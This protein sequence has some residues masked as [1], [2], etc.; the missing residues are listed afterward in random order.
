MNAIEWLGA[1]HYQICNG[2][3]EQACY[4]GYIDRLIEEW[5]NASLWVEALEKEVDE[6][7]K[8]GKA[9]IAAANMID[10]AINDLEMIVVCQ[11]CG[12]DGYYYEENEDGESEEYPCDNCDGEGSFGTDTFADIDFEFYNEW[13]NKWDSEYYTKIDMDA[14]DDLTGQS[15]THSVVLDS[16]KEAKEILN[17]NG[18]KLI[19]E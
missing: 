18:Y 3:L 6:R 11:D 10:K 7:T 13:V 15:H 5:D 17:K 19:K 1:L 12:G 8:E 4:N 9:A 2:G 14:I 16:M